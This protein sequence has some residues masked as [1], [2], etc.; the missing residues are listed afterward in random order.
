MKNLARIGLVV[1]IPILALGVIVA[2]Q[3]SGLSRAEPLPAAVPTASPEDSPAATP[4]PGPDP[5]DQGDESEGGLDLYGNDVTSAVAKYKFDGT[6]TLY[7]LH[8]PQTEVPR[9]APPKT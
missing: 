7:E 5:V 4:D 3:L 8:S 6:G 2:P 9:L 1:A